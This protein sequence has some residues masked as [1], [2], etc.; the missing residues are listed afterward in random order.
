MRWLWLWIFCLV[1]RMR[2]RESERERKDFCLHINSANGSHKNMQHTHTRKYRTNRSGPKNRH[3]KCK[4]GQIKPS[5]HCT[6][7]HDK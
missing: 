7:K 4:E 5:A 1:E 3:T 6:E 2:E